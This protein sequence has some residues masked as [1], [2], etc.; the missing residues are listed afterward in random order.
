MKKVL[1]PA[2]VS[3]VLLIALTASGCARPASNEARR[4]IMTAP[5]ASPRS[6]RLREG[7]AARAEPRP[8]VPTSDA[9]PPQG[10]EPDPLAVIDWLLKQRR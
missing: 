7:P 10:T 3:F 4:P 6:D 9:A 5:D 8:P 1:R 2:G